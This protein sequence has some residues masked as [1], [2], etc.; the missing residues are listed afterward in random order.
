[1]VMSK[2]LTNDTGMRDVVGFGLV[3]CGFDTF[4]LVD[5]GPRSCRSWALLGREI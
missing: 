5:G 4:L 2:R 1:M 3:A